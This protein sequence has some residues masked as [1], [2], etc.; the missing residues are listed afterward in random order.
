ME[1]KTGYYGE[2]RWLL[3]KSRYSV[4]TDNTIILVFTR[5][6]CAPATSDSRGD[7]PPL[8]LSEG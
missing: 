1:Y 7:L 8:P 2:V 6:Q 5:R 3:G 4:H